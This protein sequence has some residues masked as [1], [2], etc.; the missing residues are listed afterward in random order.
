MYAFAFNHSF[1]KNLLP[2]NVRHVMFS[3]GELL[4]NLT[5][6]NCSLTNIDTSVCFT[7]NEKFLCSITDTFFGIVKHFCLTAAR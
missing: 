2:R 1:C 5:S 7:G 6:A 3:S 4:C